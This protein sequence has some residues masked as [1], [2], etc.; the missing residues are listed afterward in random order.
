MPI[1]NIVSKLIAFF[2]L[3]ENKNHKTISLVFISR[4]GTCKNSHKMNVWLSEILIKALLLL[5]FLVKTYIIKNKKNKKKR[6]WLNYPDWLYQACKFTK[7][8]CNPQLSFGS[9]SLISVPNIFQIF[10][11][12]S[13][14]WWQMWVNPGQL[15]LLSTTTHLSRSKMMLWVE[16]TWFKSWVCNFLMCN[17]WQVTSLSLCFLNYIQDNE[18]THSI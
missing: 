8:L 6:P 11:K 12:L 7:Q 15:R 16:S 17:L 3:I 18:G 9:A 1:R 2:L 13:G 4:G 10:W 5:I 14:Y